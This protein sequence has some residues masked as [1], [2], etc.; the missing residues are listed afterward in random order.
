MKFE[1][2]IREK[3]GLLIG[4]AGG[5][6]S[7]KTYSAMRIASGIVGSDF[8]FA[9]IDTENRRSLHY[10]DFFNFDHLQLEPPFRPEKYID[11]IMEADKAGY[12]AVIVDSMSHVWAGEGGVLEWQ[13]EELSRIAG[14]D[15]KKREQCK[16]AAWVKPKMAHKKMVN[17]L[18]R[19]K[20]NVIICYRAEEKIEMVKNENGKTEIIKKKTLT[21]LDGWVPICE[22]NLPYEHTCS[23]LVTADAPGIP[24]PIKLEEQHR[25]IFKLTEPLSEECGK[26]IRAWAEGAEPCMKTNK[27]DIKKAIDYFESIGIK[28]QTLEAEIGK[29]SNEWNEKDMAFLKQKAKDIKSQKEKNPDRPYFDG[30]Y[31]LYFKIA[32]EEHP[33]ELKKAKALL[34][35][36]RYEIKELGESQLEGLKSAYEKYLD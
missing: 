3:V 31:E 14:N 17:S 18:L 2:A 27:D 21:G 16:M 25:H 12:N 32:S 30:D 11:A 35:L 34:E 6:G 10:A 36:E 4:I 9:V 7:G 29:E 20:A 26:A 8:R 13:E 33:E 15:Y 28:K 22:K 19:I 24:K 1:K 23:F 5:T